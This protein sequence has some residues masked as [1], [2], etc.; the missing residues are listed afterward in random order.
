MRREILL[1]RDERPELKKYIVEMIAEIVNNAWMIDEHE[2]KVYDHGVL[3][4]DLSDVF[5]IM[6]FTTE[7]ELSQ[8]A[9]GQELLDFCVEIANKAYDRR[10]EDL[11]EE[12]MSK[13]E[14]QVMLSA[15]NDKWQDHLQ[16]VEYIREGIGL[17]GYGQMDPLIAYKRETFD[18]FEQ[19]LKAIRDQAVRMIY[20][21]KLQIQQA[22]EPEMIRMDDSAD[23]SPSQP[24]KPAQAQPQ[25][26]VDWKHVGRN[27][28][29]PCG[30][31]KKFK[32]CH[33][34]KLREQGVI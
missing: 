32:A 25:G 5:P 1:G 18:L 30:S 16:L 20:Q 10:I 24:N 33:Y 17:R 3:F 22:P 2:H 7:A 23:L 31:G 21:A 11:G 26:A 13:L 6:D 34:Q 15:V 14:Q 9:P 29:C 19:T 4:Q 27:D 12:I 8:Y 28:P